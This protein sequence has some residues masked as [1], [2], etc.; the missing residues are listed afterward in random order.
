MGLFHQGGSCMGRRASCFALCFFTFVTLFAAILFGAKPVAAQVNTATLPGLVSD[1][2][3][4]AIRGAKVTAT[5]LATDAPRSITVDDDGR[6]T[7]VG[8]VPGEYKIRVEGL[9]NFAP[10]ENP[11]LQLTVG[12]V[13]VLR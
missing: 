3:G 8:L 2:Q 9:S 5:F 6:F 13:A 7:L 10:Y 1:P 11:L 4:L 12:Q